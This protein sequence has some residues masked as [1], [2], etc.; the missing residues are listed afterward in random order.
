MSADQ[1]RSTEAIKIRFA[2][3]ELNVFERSLKKA[4]ETVPLGGRAFDLLLT[5]IERSGETIG[6]DELIAQVWPD[7]TVEEGSLRVHMSALRKALG[8]GQLGRRRYIANVKGRGYCFVAPVTRQTQDSDPRNRLALPS[9]MPVQ[10]RCKADDDE[11]VLSLKALLQT[12][13]LTGTLGNGRSAVDPKPEKMNSAVIGIV[14]VFADLIASL[15][16]AAKQ[17]AEAEENV[18]ATCDE[19]VAE[20]VSR[21]HKRLAQHAATTSC[22]LRQMADEISIVDAK[23]QDHD[24]DSGP[25]RRYSAVNRPA[26]VRPSGEQPGRASSYSEA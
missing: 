9:N 14:R 21:Q 12:E 13:R 18:I 7:V 23:E 17:L 6:K 20:G 2:P 4:G 16:D 10:P 22:S 26:A 11:A 5:L 1:R 24:D 15:L 3:F 25:C 19:P 8:D